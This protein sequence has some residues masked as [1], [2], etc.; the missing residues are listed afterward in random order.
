MV[1]TSQSSG[2]TTN[3]LQREVVAMLTEVNMVVIDMHEP[4]KL[5]MK[6]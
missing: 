6:I 2:K 1:G 5:L 3:L 4:G